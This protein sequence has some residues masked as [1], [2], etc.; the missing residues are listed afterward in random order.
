MNHIHI[1]GV[2]KKFIRGEEMTGNKQIKNGAI[3]S[4]ATLIV[5][6]VFSLAYMPWMVSIIGKADYA[7]YTLAMT[8]VGMFMMDFGLGTAVSRYVSKYNAENDQKAV[9]KFISIVIKIYIFIDII[10]ISVLFVVYCSLDLIYK[11]LT[12]DELSTYKCLFIIVAIYSVASFPFIPLNGI[13]NAYE[14]FVQLKLCE[15]FQKVFAIILTVFSLML[16]GGVKWVVIVNAVSVFVTII[17]K[18]IIVKKIV[19][20]K[21]SFKITDKK[22][23]NQIFSF[24]IWIT[25]INLAQRCIFNLAPSILGVVSNSS[26]IAI[27]APANTLE[28][29]F[30]MFAAAVN[31]LFLPRISRYIVNQQENEISNLMTKLGRYQVIVLG[32]IYVEFVM[33][34]KEFMCLWMGKE[35]ISAY[36]CSV[37]LFFPD[38]L[39]Y[40]QQIANTTIIAKNKVKEQSYGYI[41]MAVVCVLLSFLLCKKY[42]ALGSC[43]SIA[44]SY[45]FLFIYSNIL[46]VKKLKFDLKKFFK[47][48]YW[49]MGGYLLIGSI[50]IYCICGFVD[51]DNYLLNFVVKGIITFI[52]YFIIVLCRLNNTEKEMIKKIIKRKE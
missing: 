19:S 41:G 18:I 42:G 31:G 52:I 15:L 44:I 33:I 21:F 1:I 40:S 46:Y 48:C 37:F 30:F 35:Y 34:G 39:L 23:I 32:F 45:M 51:F 22:L 9:E 43:V 20:F 10:I 5:N 12:P 6:T 29:F 26:E 25:I 47:E 4:Y 11:G 17:I 3:I 8:F 28:S 13:L 14:R 36:Y 27:F 7:L 24:S 16:G 38:I 2:G 49:D 50:G